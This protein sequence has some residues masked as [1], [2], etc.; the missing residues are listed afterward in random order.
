MKA[1]A[2]V[3]LLALS[4]FAQETPAPTPAQPACGPIGVNFDT[5]TS[6]AQPPAQPEPGKAQVYVAEDFPTVQPTIGSPRIK[7]GVDG[8]WMGATHGSSYLFFSIDPGEH[9]LCVK[10]QSRLERFSKLASFARL[11][12]EP[13]KTY[14]FRARIIYSSNGTNVY[15][16]LDHLDPDEGQYLVA[17]SPL[18]TSQPKK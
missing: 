10:W 9:H 8:R 1:A 6:T 18:I 3:I 17:S 7:I 2:L 13:G 4:A 12:A 14:Y 5:E 15:L 16:D 11:M